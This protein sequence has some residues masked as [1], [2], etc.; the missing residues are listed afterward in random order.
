[1]MNNR[2]FAIETE[3]V[4]EVCEYTTL[5]DFHLNFNKRRIAVDIDSPLNIIYSARENKD[6]YWKYIEILKHDYILIGHKNLSSIFMKRTEYFPERVKGYEYLKRYKNV[7]YTYTPIE[8]KKISPSLPN[9]LLVLFSH[10]NGTVKGYNNNNI[11]VRTF[12]P[13]FLDIQRSLVK[14][15]HIL[16]LGDLTLSHGSY[17]HNTSVF[18][19]YESQIQELIHNI[20]N[21]YNISNENTI[22]YGGSKGGSGALLHSS[23]GDYKAICGDPIIDLSFYNFDRNDYHFVQNF[24]PLNLSNGILQYCRTNKNKKYIFCHKNQSLNYK[25][26]CNLAKKSNGVVNIVDL[27]NDKKIIKHPDITSN[28]VP[29]QITLMNLMFDAKKIIGIDI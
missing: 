3:K 28:S 25:A 18:P 5:N 14:N 12:N 27:S 13:Y 29:E 19:D 10:M 9:R 17:Y 24:L 7:F 21:K 26:S 23:I 16:R 8:S 1:M 20:R 22:L 4:R 15:V 2:L 11:I 6:T